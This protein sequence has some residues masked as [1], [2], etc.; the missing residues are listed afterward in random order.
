L[1]DLHCH[2]LPGID[3]GAASLDDSL[4]IARLAL[5]DGV[6]RVVATPHWGEG[7]FTG[8]GAEIQE[9]VRTLQ[10]EL[11]GRGVGLEILAGAELFLSPE[12]PARCAEDPLLTLN[13]SRYLLVELPFRMVPPYAEQILFELQLQG[14]VPV[15][16]HPER[17]AEI[18]A[19][20]EL[21]RKLVDRGALAQVTAGSLEGAFGSRVRRAAETLVKGRLVQIIAS[22][23]HSARGRPPRLEGAVRRAAQ[24]VGDEAARASRSAASIPARSLGEGVPLRTGH[25][26]HRRRAPFKPLEAQH[27]PIPRHPNR[28]A[29]V[30]VALQ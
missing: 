25:L 15:I 7:A 13:G 30:E 29:L 14:I 28:V 3:D 12:V 8:T 19:N 9:R 24:L 6:R 11:L 1:I 18:T 21:L 17:N 27:V 16:A 5:Q 4:A 22:D 10:R 26:W 23:A 2:I 20:P